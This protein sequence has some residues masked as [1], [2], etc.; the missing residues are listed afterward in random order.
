[1][2]KNII[3]LCLISIILCKGPYQIENKVLVLSERTFFFAMKEFKNLLVLFYDSKNP[4][5]QDFM[6][7]YEKTAS[8]L[9]KKNFVLAKIDCIK[10]EKICNKYKIESFPTIVLFKKKELIIYDG[11]IISE[12]IEKWMIENTKPIFKK[13]TSK[14]ELERNKKYTRVFL[15]YFGND[16]KV[17]NELIL[18]ERKIDDIPIFTCDSEDLIKENVDIQKNET[19]VI[20]KTFDDKKN[21]FKDSITAKNI[22]K[23]V[24]LYSYPRA[25]EF[26]KDTAHIILEKRNPALII[27]STKSERHYGD[28][29][30]LFN[31]M[32]PRVK[33]KIKLFVCDIMD[34]SA[35]KLVQYCNIT[36]KTIPKVY[37]V[38]A[39][40]ENPSKFVM[41]GGIN[42]E[43]I[44][45]FLNKWRKGKLKPYIRSEEV[46]KNNNGDLF[47]L[48]GNNYKKEVLEN[49]KDVLIYFVSPLCKICKD[50]EP[51]LEELA[52]KL[53]P[54]NS[55]LLI[56]KMDA[57]INDVEGYQ[58]NNF[59]TIFFYPGNAKDKEPLSY[60]SIDNINGIYSFLKENAFNKII[61]EDSNKIIDL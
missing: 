31:Y 22:I 20:F 16:E 6:P 49:D 45:I 32:W 53:K 52:K 28:S 60:E 42:E 40:N 23:F 5:S 15:I 29:L 57:T 59:P 61:E 54:F 33:S 48:V 55:K 35:A 34:P 25:I 13:I 41:S 58:I 38:H 56:A 8:T 14:R 19:I 27:F 9:K 50:F 44:M 37:I 11:E 17:I 1:M 43:N 47:I 21:I 26:S 2:R 18:A 30:N 4:N 24:D 51:K 7:D 46:P 10:A 3:F 39:E 36:L 12:E